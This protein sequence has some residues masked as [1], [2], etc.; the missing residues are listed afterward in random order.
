MAA[1][2]YQKLFFI[3]HGFVFWNNL[4]YAGRYS[5]ITYSPLYYP[6]VSVIGIQVLAVLSLTAATAGYTA[7]VEREWGAGARWSA[8]VFAV[9]WAFF[10][11]SAAFP[12]ALGCALA[13]L[14]LLVLQRGMRWPFAV[15]A[16]L[17]LAASTLAFTLLV[18]VLGGI[19]LG[20]RRFPGHRHTRSAIAIVGVLGSVEVVLWALFPD[21]GR[22]PFP[23]E[24]F[25]AAV[26]FCTLGFFVTFRSERARPLAAFFSLYLVACTLAFIL[27]SPV[28]ENIARM[29]FLAIPI[30]VL[31]LS[32][33][34]WNPRILS[35]VVLLLA[36][37]WNVSPLAASFQRGH[38]DAAQSPLFW[39]EPVV[40]LRHNLDPA[41]RVEAVDTA[42]HWE[43]LYLAQAGIP[44]TRGWFRQDDFPQNGLLYD[45]LGVRGYL[46]WLRKL[47]VRYIVLTNGPLDYS[48][49]GEARLLRAHPGLFPVVLRFP[50]GVIM[51]VSNPQPLVRGGPAPAQVDLV[52]ATSI[53]FEATEPGRYTMGVRY[54]PYFSSPDACIRKLPGGFTGVTVRKAGLVTISFA[55]GAQSAART[56]I[57]RSPTCA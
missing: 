48:A 39:A 51:E 1:H 14:A 35:I 15:L 54:S 46:H 52:A 12:F 23:R 34:S 13:L 49:R 24:E 36:F 50:G 7:I 21:G 41:Y 5:F 16:A 19:A 9:V 37:S 3:Q 33:R 4:W 56:L 45:E 31:A 29:R 20:R 6:L 22:F 44:L 11:L 55:V 28:G 27:P 2:V 25:A 10:V 18:I 42:G 43:A 30:A 40:F 32:L 8:R 57:G 26:A 38:A 47:S 17:A 53:V